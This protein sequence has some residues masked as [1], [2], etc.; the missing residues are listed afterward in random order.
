MSNSLEN[1]KDSDFWKTIK[2]TPFFQK[3]K[4]QYQLF[5]AYH[6]T[7]MAYKQYIE[8]RYRMLTASSS[9][10][11]TIFAAFL[12]KSASQ[13]IAHALIDTLKLALLYHVD[14]YL[15]MPGRGMPLTS[16]L[17]PRLFLQ[18]KT[19]CFVSAHFPASDINI[20]NFKKYN[21][22]CLVHIRDPRDS[23]ISLCNHILTRHRDR[24]ALRGY[25]GTV[26]EVK[27]ALMEM[28][29]NVFPDQSVYNSFW[30]SIPVMPEATLESDSETLEWFIRNQYEMFVNW[31]RDWIAASKELKGLIHLTSYE[32]F[33]IDPELYY[34][35]IYD[36]YEVPKSYSLPPVLKKH[37]VTG[38][39]R[40]FEKVMTKEQIDFT[41]KL[42]PDIIYENT[43][44]KP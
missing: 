5:R 11:P 17:H 33:V 22:K 14:G 44:I 15:Y 37:F 42:I 8:Q 35:K 3:Y 34:R 16:S 18:P 39:S 10:S 30:D 24:Y 9:A 12:Y 20:E 31:I 13:S 27:E 32:D 25:N 23:I 28:L 41:T 7:R 4:P 1:V 21:Q 6:T 26:V 29:P 2:N 38:K 40:N 19:G 43:L 36:F